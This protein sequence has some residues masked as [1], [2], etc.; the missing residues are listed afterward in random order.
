MDEGGFSLASLDLIGFVSTWNRW[1]SIVII[2]VR[3]TNDADAD[4]SPLG[5]SW[6]LGTKGIRNKW[7]RTR[8]DKSRLLLKA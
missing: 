2:E 1:T 4:Y 5:G 8:R 6:G 7:T 3:P